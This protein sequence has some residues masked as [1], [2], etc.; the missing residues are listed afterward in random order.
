L[1]NFRGAIRDLC[2]SHFINAKAFLPGIADQ[3]GSSYTVIT[4]SAGAKSI[5]LE[6]ALTTVGAAAV[7]GV[8]EALRFQYK[9][10]KVLLNYYHSNQEQVRVNEFR[11]GAR[12]VR[13]EDL[14]QPWENSHL[15]MGEAVLG[16]VSSSLRNQITVS[17]SKESLEKNRKGQF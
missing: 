8:A 13:D 7:F 6:S 10:S 5:S 12:V 3:E 2:E 17:D 1:E 14:K 15:L 9:D 11:L 16:L 4:G